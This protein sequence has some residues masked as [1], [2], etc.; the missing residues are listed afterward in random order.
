MA[1]FVVEEGLSVV[2]S[3]IFAKSFNPD[4]ALPLCE[5]FGRGSVHPL[6]GIARTRGTPCRDM[7]FRKIL[8]KRVIAVTG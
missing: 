5:P 1:F 6:S 4:G 8:K 2:G 3:G 7:A